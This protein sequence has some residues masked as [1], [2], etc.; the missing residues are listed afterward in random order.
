MLKFTG[1]RFLF[2]EGYF[3]VDFESVILIN[4]A[5]KGVRLTE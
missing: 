3:V 5:I 4:I 1:Y 2:L